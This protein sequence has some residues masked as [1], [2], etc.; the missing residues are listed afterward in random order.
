MTRYITLNKKQLW[1]ELD[2][3]TAYR[4][5]QFCKHIGHANRILDIGCNTGR[6][7]IIIQ[8]KTHNSELYGLDCVRSRLNKIPKHVYAK[9]LCGY[10]TDIPIKNSYFD[11]VVAGEFIEHLTMQD[12]VVTIK[13]ANRILKKGGTLQ[14]TTPNPEGIIYR[15]S[16]SKIIGGPHLS[17]HKASDLKSKLK[18]NGFNHVRIF[19]SGRASKYIGEHFPTCFYNSYLIVARKK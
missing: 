15:L 8:G 10:S 1:S 18:E 17:E 11:A 7:G 3:F 9:L 14:M 19:G 13:E 4:Y 6:G 5:K 16:G 2:S 12:V